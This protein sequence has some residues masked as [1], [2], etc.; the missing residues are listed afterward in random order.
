MSASQFG[1]GRGYIDREA[2]D[3]TLPRDPYRAVRAQITTQPVR[4]STAFESLLVFV[5][6]TAA[7]QKDYWP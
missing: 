2:G 5:P 1:F 4:G 7:Q 3:V 6:S